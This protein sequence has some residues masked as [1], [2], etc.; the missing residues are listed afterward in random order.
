MAVISV[1]PRKSWLVA[2]WAFLGFLEQVR[3]TITDV[4]LRGTIEQA[5]A[6]DGLHLHTLT[7]KERA[8]LVPALL[9]VADEFIAGKRRLRVE[10]RTLDDD[11]Q[12]QVREAL[13]ELRDLLTLGGGRNP[14]A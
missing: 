7:E 3:E 8:R 11:S 12:A 13:V 10:G 2:R 5:M 1:A 6:L 4:G 14:T 9:A